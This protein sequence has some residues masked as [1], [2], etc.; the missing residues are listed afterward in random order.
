MKIRIKIPRITGVFIALLAITSVVQGGWS[1]APLISENKPMTGNSTPLA[2]Y[3]EPSENATS[4]RKATTLVNKD[5]NSTDIATHL[6]HDYCIKKHGTLEL[7]DN[8][9]NFLLLDVT[10]TNNRE[11][12]SNYDSLET[13]NIITEFGKINFVDQ[14]NG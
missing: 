5:K 2:S 10:L 4:K 9:H 14:V 6:V 8:I 13:A 12:Y 3:S 11:Y 7:E 1:G